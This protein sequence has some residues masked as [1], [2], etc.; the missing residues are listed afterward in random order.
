MI[1][2]HNLGVMRRIY[3]GSCHIFILLYVWV[4]IYHFSIP[5][6]T[7]KKTSFSAAWVDFEVRTIIRGANSSFPVVVAEVGRFG[8]QLSF[9]FKY[10][11]EVLCFETV[12]IVDVS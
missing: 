8:N 1:V 9:P 7:E 3:F 10:R 4:H 11:S 5:F 2:E 12:S 6:I